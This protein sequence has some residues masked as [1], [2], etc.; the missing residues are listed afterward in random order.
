MEQAVLGLPG[1]VRRVPLR[2]A[3]ELLR[4]ALFP[5]K[6]RAS[7]RELPPPAG[8]GGPRWPPTA[9]GHLLPPPAAGEGVIPEPRERPVTPY[10]QRCDA[11]ETSRVRTLVDR[12]RWPSGWRAF[13][14]G[15]ARVLA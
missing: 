3:A 15:I 9:G 8:D 12:T 6:A 2:R 14:R 11:S 10:I 13:W 4:Y 7:A 1:E 5:R